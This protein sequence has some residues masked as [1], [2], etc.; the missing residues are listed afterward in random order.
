MITDKLFNELNK[1]IKK[2]SYPD[3]IKPVPN[4]RIEGNA[5]F[6]GVMVCMI[7]KTLERL[8]S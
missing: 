5:F 3:G 1:I 8:K 7:T 4:E 2:E 6:P